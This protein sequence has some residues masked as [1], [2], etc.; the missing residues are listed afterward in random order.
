MSFVGWFDKHSLDH[1]S[2]PFAFFKAFVPESLTN[3]WCTYTNTKALR[4]NAGQPRQV[5]P[6]FKP[7]TCLEF[8]QYI[9]VYIAHGISPS[10]RIELKFK[11]QSKDMCNG[12]NFISRMIG[13][14][15][16]RRHKHWR[17]FLGTQDPLKVAYCCS[18]D[19]LW[20]VRGF[21]DHMQKRST[22]S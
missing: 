7:F 16:T 3:K 13:P 15:P 4:D 10:P 5:Y 1:N 11:T 9:G 8:C 2:S 20:K 6:D 17:R 14:N 18:K 21:F 22:T 19:P 12:N